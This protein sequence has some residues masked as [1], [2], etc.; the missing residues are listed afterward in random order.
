MYEKSEGKG[1]ERHVRGEEKVSVMTS[2]IQEELQQSMSKTI[3]VYQVLMM[4]KY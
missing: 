2:V 4:I 3:R 1:S